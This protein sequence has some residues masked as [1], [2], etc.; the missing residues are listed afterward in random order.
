MRRLD[1]RRV[2]FRTSID[3]EDDEDGLSRQILRNLVYQNVLTMERYLPGLRD[4]MGGASPAEAIA[5][6][7]KTKAEP[8]AP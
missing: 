1:E 3:V 5:R 7:E 2:Q 8:Q 4:V 6:A